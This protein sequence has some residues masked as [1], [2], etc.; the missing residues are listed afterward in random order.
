MS[1]PHQPLDQWQILI[2]DCHRLVEQISRRPGSIKL[3]TGAK[4]ALQTYAQYKSGR[5]R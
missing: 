2:T 3:L 5:G 4:Q 1:Q